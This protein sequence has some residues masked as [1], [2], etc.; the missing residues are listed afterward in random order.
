MVPNHMALTTECVFLDIIHE[1]AFFWSLVSYL[2]DFRW[3]STLF[4]DILIIEIFAFT[5][6]KWGQSSICSDKLPICATKSSL[7]SKSASHTKGLGW[8]LCDVFR[9]KFKEMIMGKCIFI[10]YS[11][12]TWRKIICRTRWHMNSPTLYYFIILPA[13]N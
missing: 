10:L 8:V 13:T 5:H 2:T 12:C 6:K 7:T 9:L 4:A 11:H 1:Y 3:C